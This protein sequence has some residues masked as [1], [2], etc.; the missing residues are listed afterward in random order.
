MNHTNQKWQ[1]LLPFCECREFFLFFFWFVSW[2]C[3]FIVNDFLFVLAVFICCFCFLEIFRSYCL[4]QAMT[5]NRIIL[6]DRYPTFVQYLFYFIFTRML[7]DDIHCFY[8]TLTISRKVTICRG[9]LWK[10]NVASCP[11][12]YTTIYIYL[13]VHC[14]V[15]VIVCTWYVLVSHKNKFYELYCV[16]IGRINERARC[17]ARFWFRMCHTHTH[18]LIQIWIRKCSNRENNL[19]FLQTFEI[20]FFFAQFNDWNEFFY[21]TTVHI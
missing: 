18:S 13:F 5:L 6:L 20:D 21:V 17:N 19:F 3:S 14:I 9:G 15:Y 1:K 7:T 4:L 10:L 16:D 12:Q 11:I 2:F 8:L